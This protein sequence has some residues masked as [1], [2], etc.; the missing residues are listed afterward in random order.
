MPERQ[1]ADGITQVKNVALHL[2]RIKTKGDGILKAWARLAQHAKQETSRSATHRRLPIF[3]EGPPPIAS[4]LP[5]LCPKE[6]RDVTTS[7]CVTASS[8]LSSQM[9]SSRSQVTCI[10]QRRTLA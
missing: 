9:G 8:A 5:T 10:M 6:S 2:S 4:K 1:L 3:A 7:T